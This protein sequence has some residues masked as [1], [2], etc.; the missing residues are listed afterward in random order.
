M[1]NTGETAAPSGT[2]TE[3]GTAATVGSPLDRVTTAPPTGACPFSVALLLAVDLPPTT[4]PGDSLTAVSAA[5]LTVSV[6]PFVFAPSLA[7]IVT[8]VEVATAA[9]VMVN[10]GE[11][12]E[13]AATVTEAGT[14]ATVASELVSVIVAP[15]DGAAEASVTV[16]AVVELAP[17]AEV[18]ESVTLWMAMPFTL[19]REKATE[20]LNN[21]AAT[22]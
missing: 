13:P 9:V 16:L 21:V 5:G 6:A 18:G 4:V 17:I 14:A 19:V 20:R 7:L 10:G 8:E 15:L 2:I 1:V 11:T 22:V 3:A 12:V